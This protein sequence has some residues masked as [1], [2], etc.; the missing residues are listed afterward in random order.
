MYSIVLKDGTI[1][2]IK[3]TE[4]EWFETSRMIRLSND[5]YTVARIN[6]DNIVGWIDKDYIKKKVRKYEQ[7][8]EDT[9][10]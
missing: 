3:A 4:V 5:G 10:I 6:M 7:R 9:G 1:I 8:K 2:N